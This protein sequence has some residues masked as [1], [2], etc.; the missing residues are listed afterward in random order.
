MAFVTRFFKV[1]Q[2][3]GRRHSECECGWSVGTRD[4]VVVLQLDTYGSAD[5]KMEQK[6][7]QSIQLDEHAARELVKLLEVAFPRLLRDR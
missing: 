7:S 5:R 3:N 6:V 1:P 4:D 2:P